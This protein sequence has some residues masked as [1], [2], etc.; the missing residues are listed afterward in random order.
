M[1]LGVVAGRTRRG[2]GAGAAEPTPEQAREPLSAMSGQ[3]VYAANH[4]Q[5]SDSL[6]L[7]EDGMA[8]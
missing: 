6:V 1:N 3:A 7:T 4:K 2:A 5:W 8:G